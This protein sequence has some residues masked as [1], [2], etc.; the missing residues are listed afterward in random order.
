MIK[1]II[2]LLTKIKNENYNKNF[3]IINSENIIKNKFFY[4]KIFL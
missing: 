1:Y 2:Y 4:K 3:I